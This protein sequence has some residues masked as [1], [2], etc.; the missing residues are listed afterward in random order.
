[1][2]KQNNVNYVLTLEVKKKKGNK[3]TTKYTL[4]PEA[5]CQRSEALILLA[6][7]NVFPG[8]FLSCAIS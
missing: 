3:K 7:N 2:S 1:M 4:H 5:D 8:M 6:G